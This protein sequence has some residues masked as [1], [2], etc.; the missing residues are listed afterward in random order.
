MIISRQCQKATFINIC[1]I[2][3]FFPSVSLNEGR[4]QMCYLMTR[5]T[6]FIL[7]LYGVSH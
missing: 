3:F 5:S 2:D 7:W 6:H 1:N 4:M